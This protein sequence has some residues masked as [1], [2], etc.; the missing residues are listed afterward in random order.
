MRKLAV[1]ISHPIQYY[2]PWFRSL[3]ADPEIQLRVFYL[4]D[5]GVTA[6]VD[7][8]FGQVI[9][10]DVPLLD[11]YDYEWVA[12]TSNQPGT[13]HIRGLQNPTLIAQVKAYQPDAVLLMNYNYASIYHFLWHWRDCPVLFRGDSHRLVPDRGVKAWLRRQWISA[14]YQRFD[15]ILYVGQANYDYF[16]HHHV[17]KEKLY[18][19]PHAIENQRFTSQI[20]TATIAAQQWKRTL[21]IPASD[22]VVLFSGKLI[23]KKRPI[24]L[25][26]AFITAKIPN[27]SL[28]FVGSGRLESE[29]RSRARGHSNIFFAPFQ[30]QSLMPRTY[31]IGDLFVLPSYGNGETWGLAVNEAMCLGKSIIVSNHVGCAQDLV[32]PNQN[33]LI[34]PAGNI[35]ALRVCLQ[36][37]FQSSKVLTA[38]GQHSR[39]M[40]EHHSYAQFTA[41]LKQA[42]ISLDDKLYA[43][44][45]STQTRST[46]DL[47]ET[48]D[49]PFLG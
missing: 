25:L 27:T 49:I 30:N 4:W 48:R 46:I 24:D 12:N 19:A 1:I 32:H 47:A 3:N 23:P 10:W 7:R 26:E 28:L 16:R 31:A 17:G 18:L 6:S 42:L 22:R 21:G 20:D 14:V 41:G 13:H 45:G 11:G 2:A 43:I 44:A 38:W 40:I 37:A 34:F 35:A 29:L 15:R 5:F 36:Q 39:Q 33:G 8:D 9:E